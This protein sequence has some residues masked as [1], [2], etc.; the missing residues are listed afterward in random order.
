MDGLRGLVTGHEQWPRCRSYIKCPT[1][2][3][4]F[5]VFMV[6]LYRIFDDLQGGWGG[7]N[8]VE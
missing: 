8:I 2:G 5:D 6:H 1:V 7:L 4:W 3:K